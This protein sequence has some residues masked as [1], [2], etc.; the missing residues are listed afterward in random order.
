MERRKWTGQQKLHIVLEGMSGK[1]PLAELCQIHG[2]SQA[3]FYQWKERLLKDGAK[4]FERGGSEASEERLKQEVRELKGIIGE[5]T[6]EL[7]KT[8]LDW[9]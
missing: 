2:I 9:L 5:L 3:Q 8:E 6:V 1:A 4:V 7:K